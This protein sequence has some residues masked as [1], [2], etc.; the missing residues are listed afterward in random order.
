MANAKS[1][2]SKLLSLLQTDNMDLKNGERMDKG[3][4]HYITKRRYNMIDKNSQI[5]SDSPKLRFICNPGYEAVQSLYVM[6]DPGHHEDCLQW[7]EQTWSELSP[8]LKKEI[9]RLLAGSKGWSIL[10]DFWT[11]SPGMDL[12]WNCTSDQFKQNLN[13]IRNMNEPDFSI[14]YLGLTTEDVEPER[15]LEWFG[16]PEV[17]TPQE[18]DFLLRI[19]SRK[20]VEY[21][22][23]HMDE[24][25]SRFVWVM[26]T[27]WQEY[28]QYVWPKIATYINI[29]SETIIEKWEGSD[30]TKY[31]RKVH[32]DV[33][34]DDDYFLFLKDPDYG[35]QLKDV[36]EARMMLS[37]FSAPHL[38]ANTIGTLLT[39]SH[40]IRFRYSVIKDEM[41]QSSR[42]CINALNDKTRCRIIKYIWEE[43]HTTQEIAQMIGISD[44]G[45]S[46]HLKLLKK[47]GLVDVKRIKK[48]VFY[49]I[50]KDVLRNAWN[51]IERYMES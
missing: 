17:I 38:M 18:W 47:A 12:P 16:H 43:F 24:A 10:C 42:L 11:I 34:T 49:R 27:Y 44:G 22:L 20:Q 26:W 2:V 4:R 28:F 31:M 50:R 30:L 5:G 36:S 41:A 25:K 40:D 15:I 7:A 9:K 35:I 8:S 6:N 29:E 39:G 3:Y 14:M 37:V 19:M 33:I 21:Y 1:F 45:V 48:R 13:A 51:E 23:T 32:K 46:L